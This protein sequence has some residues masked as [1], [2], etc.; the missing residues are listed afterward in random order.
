MTKMERQH[1]D[2]ASMTAH[3][4]P[5][6][7]FVL[8]LALWASLRHG[9]GRPL[10][11]AQEGHADDDVRAATLRSKRCACSSAHDSECHYFCHLDIIWVNTASKTTLYGLGGAAARQRRSAGRCAC[12]HLHDLTCARFCYQRGV[13]SKSE[14]VRSSSD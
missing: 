5:R 3:P 2:D 14:K 4:S 10:A 11:K 8:F 6:V 13:T 9:C 1:T 7:G 12:A